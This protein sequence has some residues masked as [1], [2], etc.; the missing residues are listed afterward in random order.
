MRTAVFVAGLLALQPIEVHAAPAAA[1][2]TVET[3]APEQPAV[4]SLVVQVAVDLDPAYDDALADALRTEVE[5]AAVAAGHAVA[6]APAP[7]SAA[8]SA[9]APR[10]HLTVGWSAPGSG[11]IR[12]EYRVDGG[13]R[14]EGAGPW[15]FTRQ[16]DTCDA[17]TLVEAVRAEIGRVLKELEPTAPAAAPEPTPVPPPAPAEPRRRPLSRLGWAGV[18]VAIG[19]VLPLPAGIVLTVRGETRRLVPTDATVY[20]VTDYRTPGL[21]LIGVAAGMVATGVILVVADRVRARR[22]GRR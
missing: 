11:D 22:G 13:A 3:R 5:S 12:I 2:L 20:E 14:A 8:P 10:V 9:S 15:V 1:V 21:A 18:G 6:Q 16:C 19:T 4:A 7:G 17:T